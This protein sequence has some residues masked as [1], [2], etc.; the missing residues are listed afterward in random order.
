MGTSVPAVAGNV[1]LPLVKVYVGDESLAVLEF[2]VIAT[3]QPL[4]GP[5]FA[6]INI[7]VESYVGVIDLP[8]VGVIAI[9]LTDVSAATARNDTVK[10]YTADLP[11]AEYLDQRTFQT[12]I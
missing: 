10:V 4:N 12:G 5:T 7:F 1:A 9:D 6:V 8:P 11:E 3:L 2:R